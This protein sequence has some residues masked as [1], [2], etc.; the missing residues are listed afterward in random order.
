VRLL[1]VVIDLSGSLNE[2]RSSEFFTVGGCRSFPA[3]RGFREGCGLGSA[4]A[5]DRDLLCGWESAK[6]WS[7]REARCFVC[8]SIMAWFLRDV[9]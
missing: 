2:L 9:R 5:F 3:R 8:A 4:L 7:S 6:S 1:A